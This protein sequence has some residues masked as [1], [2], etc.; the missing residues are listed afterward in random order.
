M[1]NIKKMFWAVAVCL[2]LLFS[3]CAREDPPF[4]FYGFPDAGPSYVHRTAAS[5]FETPEPG[6]F[7][8]F[9][10]R[11][12]AF[13][14]AGEYQLAIEDL[15]RVLVYYGQM[16]VPAVGTRALAFMNAGDYAR[17]LQDINVLGIN[18][19]TEAPNDAWLSHMSGLIHT[20]MGNLEQGQE[21]ILVAIMLDPYYSGLAQEHLRFFRNRIRNAPR[22]TY[23]RETRRWLLDITR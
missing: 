16:T 2:S 1:A 10:D 17:A 21:S 22:N 14:K 9:L 4:F 6:N 7:N 11:A 3:G 13:I 23:S 15:N 12:V 8:G 5:S 18:F 20:L 19:F